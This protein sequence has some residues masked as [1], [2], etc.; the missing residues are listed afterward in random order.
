[1]NNKSNIITTLYFIYITLLIVYTVIK[2][3]TS[4]IVHCLV[5]IYCLL[6]AAKILE[7]RN[8]YI[9][10]MPKGTRLNY[11]NYGDE[12]DIKR[13]KLEHLYTT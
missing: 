6:K 7:D 11:L 8:K 5:L 1:M 4:L 12:L 13:L 9:N 2:I 10:H 3:S